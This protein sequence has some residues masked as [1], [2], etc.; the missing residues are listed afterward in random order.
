[1]ADALY[2]AL[3]AARVESLMR[4]AGQVMKLDRMGASHQTRLS[5]MRAILR[6]VK[7][8]GWQVERTVW[9]VNDKG[10]GVG[11]YEASGP[12]RT[13][14]LIAY[15]NDLPPEKRSDRVIATE[16]DAT[17]ALFDG[18]PTSA[19]IE[20]LRNNVPMQEAGRCSAAELVLSRANR[21]VR[22]FDYVVE[23]LAAGQQPDAAELDNVG[24]LMR[25]TAVYGNGKFGL[26]D[27]AKYA[28]RAEASGPFRAEL[29]AVWL[30]RSFTVDIVEHMAHVRGGDKAVRVDRGL[31]RRL[32][33]GNSTGLG[34]APFLVNHPALLNAWIIARETALARVRALPSAMPE[35][36][37][38]FNDLVARA[39][40][41]LARWHTPDERQAARIGELSVDFDELKAHLASGALGQPDPWNVLYQWA[42]SNLTLEGVEA[43]VSLIIEP[44]GALVDDLAD[45]MAADEA[46]PFLIEGRMS[47]ASLKNLAREKFGWALK[48][49]FT[50]PDQTARFWYVSE[51]KL[52]PRLGERH[53]EDGAGLEQ[54]LGI[55]REVDLM[56]VDLEA[57]KPD[58]LVAEF[59]LA[60]P[61]H[62]H[63]AR[64]VQLS[65]QLPY[66]EIHD[67][68]LSATMMP[69]D[70]LRCKLAFFGASR[71]DPKSDRWVRITMY[72]DAP[73]PDEIDEMEAD[74]WAWPPQGAAS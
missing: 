35:T 29:L 66:A 41:D 52:E 47:V 6:R 26:S 25:T 17:F 51:E 63:A 24:Y 60:H 64:R 13:Y 5:F 71:F 10:V 73:F 45:E 30:I 56:M 22:L 69:I 59:L 3:D 50:S 31:R 43:V 74:D 55:G 58:M 8:E 11:V 34:M 36:I 19:D 67:N 53:E 62:R 42:E 44:H 4:P 57:Q 39:Q 16:W 23:K 38:Q 40:A 48:T 27:R 72:A 68:V 61:E 1:M 2:S 28:G 20:R 46:V 9:D 18:V 15:A 33:V 12:E 70:M 7:A 37:D 49:D 14:S 21:S 65:E 54:R 32:G